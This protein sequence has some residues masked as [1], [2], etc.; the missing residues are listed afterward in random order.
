MFENRVLRIFGAERAEVIRELRKLNNEQLNDLY[1]SPNTIRVIKLKIMRLAGHVACLGRVEAY[2][3]FC[4]DNLR[5]RDHLG[6]PDID[7]MIILI[8]IFREWDVG[9]W[10]GLKWLRIGTGGGRL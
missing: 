7:E 2:I 8:C 10:T 4:C 5:E 6:D 9:V 1:S 3:G